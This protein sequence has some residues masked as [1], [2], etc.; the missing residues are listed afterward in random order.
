[1][2]EARLK[3][4]KGAS[5]FVKSQLKRL[6]QEDDTWE[7]DFLPI[8]C[9]DSEHGSVWWGIVLSHDHDKVLAQRM[10]EEPPTVNDLAN[11]LAEAMR[12]PLVDFSHRPRCLLLRA[13]PEWAE[14]LPHLKQVAIKAVA[15]DTLPKWDRNFGDLQAQVERTRA[16]AAPRGRNVMPDN[17]DNKAFQELVRVL[18][19]A[20]RGGVNSIGLEYKGRELMV[21]H[22]AGPLGLGAGRI[23]DEL[24]Q[25]VI[26]ELVKRAGLSRKSRGKLQVN[27]L[28][29]DYDA[30]VEEYDSFGESAFNLTLRERKKTGG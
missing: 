8:P 14:L 5:F 18:E 30:I 1:M 24:R 6:R 10:V 7:A 4:G 19:E 23:A 12:R 27:L 20:V 2:P 15:Q 13:R 28:G 29:K 17:A 16:T 22:Q 9:S 25:A 11:L 21:F 26:A 3:L